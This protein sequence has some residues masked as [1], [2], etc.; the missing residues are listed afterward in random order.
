[1]RRGVGK[2]VGVSSGKVAVGGRAGL[3]SVDGGLHAGHVRR[4]GWNRHIVNGL[5]RVGPH[6]PA[7][8]RVMVMDVGAAGRSHALRHAVRGLAGHGWQ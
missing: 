6:V 7:H 8:F 1:M 5:H 2:V 4:N 3:T